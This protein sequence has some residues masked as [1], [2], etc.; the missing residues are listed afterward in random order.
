MINYKINKMLKLEKKMN[1]KSQIEKWKN[2]AS[3]LYTE[4]KQ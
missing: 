2:S 4:C 3:G 1:K